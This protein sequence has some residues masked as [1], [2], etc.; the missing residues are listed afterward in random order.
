[1]LFRQL[2]VLALVA[3]TSLA[4]SQMAHEQKTVTPLLQY[5]TLAPQSTPVIYHAQTFDSTPRQLPV[6]PAAATA[7]AGKI[8]FRSF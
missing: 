7:A 3:G 2:V 4:D 1:M 6:V 5:E 8:T